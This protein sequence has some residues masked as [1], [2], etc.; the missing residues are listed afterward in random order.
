MSTPVHAVATP[1]NTCRASRACRNARVEP[2]YPTGATQH[3]TFPCADMHGL[4][5]VS[6][7]DVGLNDRFC[8]SLKCRFCVNGA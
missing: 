6:C 2:C 5:S 3:V 4:G 8:A 7:R 1:L